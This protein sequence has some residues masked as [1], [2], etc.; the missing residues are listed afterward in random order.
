MELSVC[1]GVKVPLCP[2]FLR[3]CIPKTP[4]RSLFV[5]QSKVSDKDIQFYG[6]HPSG[7]LRRKR[8]VGRGCAEIGVPLERNV[9]APWQ[10]SSFS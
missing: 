9:G 2:P 4:N 6:S 5:P 3:L 10:P 8:I 7:F 1:E